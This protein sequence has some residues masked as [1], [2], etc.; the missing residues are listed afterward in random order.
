VVWNKLTATQS[1]IVDPP[2][3]KLDHKRKCDN[4]RV[5]DSENWNLDPICI[6]SFKTGIRPIQR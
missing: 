4:K 1:I 3:L 5:N 6:D 2:L